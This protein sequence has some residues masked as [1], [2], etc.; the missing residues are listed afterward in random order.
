MAAEL[1]TVPFQ[2]V[3]VSGLAV[4]GATI[5]FYDT[6]TSTKLPI[7]TTSALTTQQTNPVVAN[8]AGNIPDTYLNT[9]NTYRVVIKNKVGTV[10]EDIDPY[11]PG[12]TTLGIT[13]TSASG[14]SVNSRGALAALS[15]VVNNQVAFLTEA[16]REGMFVFSTAN[17]SASVTADPAEAFYVAPAS[18]STGASGAWVRRYAGAK[19]ATW[20]GATGDGSTDDA[21][22]L[23]R[24]LDSGGLLFL[25]GN[26][27][28][29]SAKLII[30]RTVNVFG[31]G[32]G[33]DEY[34]STAGTLTPS[35]R[36]VF[37]AGI[38]GLDIQ[39][40]VSTTTFPAG[41]ATQEG[42]YNSQIRDIALIGG[43]GA[44]ATGLYC[45]TLVHLTNVHVIGFSGK[46]FDISAGLTA[47]GNSE[48]GNA[49]LSTL[50]RCTAQSIGSHGFHIRGN[51]ANVIKLDSCNSNTNTE[52][53]FLDEGFLG[54]Q[55]TNC[56]AAG[57]VGGSYKAIGS[58]ANHTF[59][60]CYVEDDGGRQCDI[61]YRCVVSGGPLTGA[62]LLYNTGTNGIPQIVGAAG[63]VFTSIQL[64]TAQN[65]L[66]AIVDT[67]YLSRHA[68]DGAVIQGA[69]AAADITLKNK[70]DQA[71]LAVATGTRNTTIYGHLA[72]GLTGNLWIGDRAP[73]INAAAGAAGATPTAAEFGALVTKFNTLLTYL[74][75]SGAGYHGL[76]T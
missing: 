29:S 65:A 3:V 68:N 52:F 24:W 59:T 73:T 55:Y 67:A 18:A 38:G 5:T 72:D 39:P 74:S 44:T 42:G 10:L 56:H 50:T 70:N 14:Q 7:Y 53:G 43:G 57:N 76:L 41:A 27:Y 8:G 64:K 26:N 6:G 46:G 34:R 69:G 21:L 36:I 47:D 66:G 4:P 49:S 32:F 30:R 23:Q 63:E 31:G 51:D 40:Q 62:A 16:G 12:V 22:A 13:L 71:V 19:I 2:C 45:R 15:P 58:V 61:S 11:I 48:Y 54:N 28:R 20:F 33:F 35:A 25:P 75:A 37:D 60:G 9:A 1:F 17:L